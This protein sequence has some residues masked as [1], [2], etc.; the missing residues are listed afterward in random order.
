MNFVLIWLDDDSANYVIII[1]AFFLIVIKWKKPHVY[2]HLSEVRMQIKTL[3]KSHVAFD[4]V[5]LSA[6]RDDPSALSSSFLRDLCFLGPRYTQIKPNRGVLVTLFYWIILFFSHTKTFLS[7]LL[8][9]Y[10]FSHINKKVKHINYFFPMKIG[11]LIKF[12]LIQR[13]LRFFKE[14]K[15]L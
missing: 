15:D 12:K 10:F 7:L 2:S 11:I 5:S 4:E 13:Q 3:V 9:H 6:S 1:Y 8:L 14:K